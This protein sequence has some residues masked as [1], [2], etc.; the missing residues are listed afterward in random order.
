MAVTIDDSP[1][2]W[3]IQA[4]RPADH[5]ADAISQKTWHSGIFK[6]PVEGRVW[7]DTDQLDGDGQ[8][9]L[10]NHGGAYRVILGYGAAHYPTW[11]AELGF[12]LPYGAF[13]E[14]FTISHL[15]EDTVSLGDR[16]AVGDAILEVSQPRQPCWKLARRWGIK[17]LTAR[18]E[19]RGWGGW[20]HRVIQPGYVGAGDGYR[21]IERPHPDCTIAR[22][23]D[24]VTKRIVDFD[25]MAALSEVDALTPEWRAWFAEKS[26]AAANTNA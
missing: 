23:N 3:S 24:L 12:D 8:A 11:R 22:I 10:V 19:A 21:L 1:I 6:F 9:D 14:N 2:L 18:V 20:Y 13:G 5:G 17:D 4:G 25:F 15:T 7:L 16:Y 26:A